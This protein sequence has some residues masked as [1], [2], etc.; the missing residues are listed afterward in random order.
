MEGQ[1]PEWMQAFMAQQHQQMEA[2][3]EQQ[4]A[5]IQALQAALANT[6]SELEALRRTTPAETPAG[7]PPPPS[8]PTLAPTTNRPARIKAILPDPPKFDGTRSDYEGWRSLARDKID[9][10]GEVIGSNWNQ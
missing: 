7:V 9:V 3:Q 1:I 6:N 5:Q 10:D 4:E 2:M 8:E